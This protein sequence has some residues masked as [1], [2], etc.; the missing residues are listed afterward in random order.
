MPDGLLT[1][2]AQGLVARDDVD[3]VVE[4][5]GGIEPARG[6][7]LSALEHGAAV[8]TANKALLAA[9]GPHPLRGRRQGRPRPV[10]RG[11]GGRGDP[12]PAAAARVARR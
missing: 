2:D 9:D 10:L 3:L 6:L 8:V 12:D 7:I 11:R 1:T 4:V 5:I